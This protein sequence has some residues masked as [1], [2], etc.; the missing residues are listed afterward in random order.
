MSDLPKNTE[1]E[2]MPDI[3]KKN[4]IVQNFGWATLIMIVG[5]MVSLYA[6]VSWQI[7][8]LESKVTAVECRLTETNSR[9]SKIEDRVLLLEL[10]KSRDGLRQE[11]QEAS[12]S[13]LE[14][15]LAEIEKEVFPR[16]Q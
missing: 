7:A 11:V 15:K 8:P 4:E 6:V 10:W 12:V 3:K 2:V 5:F 9:I 16:R 14:K 13:R 1:G